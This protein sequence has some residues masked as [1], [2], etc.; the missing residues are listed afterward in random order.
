MLWNEIKRQAVWQDAI[1]R[2]SPPPKKQ[3]WVL[4]QIHNITGLLE[5]L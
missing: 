4:A 3:I 5:S 2:F 1:R